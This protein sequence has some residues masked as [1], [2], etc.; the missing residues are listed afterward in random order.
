MGECEV[1]S[2]TQGTLLLKH[3]GNILTL[4]LKQLTAIKQEDEAGI[5]TIIAQKQLIIEHIK[6]LQAEHGNM[7]FSVDTTNKLQQLLTDIKKAE[8]EGQAILV[9]RQETLRNK[10]VSI[11]QK[12]LLQ[13]YETPFVSK[14]V[15]SRSK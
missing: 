6:G 5:D 12:K 8:D 15:V 7:S 13:A 9:Q 4:S 3:Y 14:P 11:Q 10:L 2:E 1:K